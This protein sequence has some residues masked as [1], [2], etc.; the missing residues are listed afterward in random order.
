[1]IL[2]GVTMKMVLEIF[3]NIGTNLGVI[4]ATGI[5]LP[6]VSAG[7]T[8]TVMTLFS[9]GVVQSIINSSNISKNNRNIID[10]Y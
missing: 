7:G 8:I 4:P 3:I 2:I 10:N 5:P 9:L 1:M 6:L